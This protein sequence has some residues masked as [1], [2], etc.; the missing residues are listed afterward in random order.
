[1]RDAKLL[2]C[3]AVKPQPMRLNKQGETKMLDYGVR[4]Q[5]S[6]GREMCVVVKEKF[7]HTA[8]ARK[9]YCGKLEKTDDNFI[10]FISWS[11]PPEEE[12]K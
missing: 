6:Q 2:F 8:E 10:E 7:F 1:M 3:L 5:A 12:E 4:W 11:N 9:K